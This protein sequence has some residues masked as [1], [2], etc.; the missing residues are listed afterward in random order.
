MNRRAQIAMTPDEVTAFLGERRTLTLA[1]LLPDGR[2]HLVAMWFALL[3]DAIHM[4]TYASSQKVRNLE[5]DAR[6]SLLAEAG[7]S[8][9]Q[10]RGVMIAADV[11]L[12]RDRGVVTDIGLAIAARYGGGLPDDP[13]ERAGVRAG[14]E[15]QAAKRVGLRMDAL[16]VASW[17]HRKL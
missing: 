2:P 9:D 15:R 11:T 1:T 17:D 7:D 8:Y 4:W 12:L 6:A 3:D 14:V 10:L 16:D 13:A 5:R